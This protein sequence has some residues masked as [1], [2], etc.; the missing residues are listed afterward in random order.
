MSGAPVSADRARCGAGPARGDAEPGAAG[1]L[2]PKPWKRAALGAAAQG[3]CPTGTGLCPH[4]RG[5]LGNPA[6]VRTTY[7]ENSEKGHGKGGEGAWL[8]AETRFLFQENPVG[9][10]VRGAGGRQHSKALGQS[11]P[12]GRAKAVCDCLSV[13]QVLGEHHDL[14]TPTP[15]P[16]T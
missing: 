2:G 4:A 15:F 12:G 16:W 9:S 7:G 8:S 11:F 1:D 13:Q 10:P 5:G 6:W 3:M 14:C